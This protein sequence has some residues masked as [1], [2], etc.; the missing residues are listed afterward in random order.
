M[1]VYVRSPTLYVGEHSYGLYAIPALVSHPAE[2]THA[3]VLLIEGPKSPIHS[4]NVLVGKFK[5]KH[6]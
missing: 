3:R 6:F 5:T 4:G 1:C 2:L